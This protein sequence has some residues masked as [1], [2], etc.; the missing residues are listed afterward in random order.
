MELDNGGNI[1]FDFSISK[2]DTW[3]CRIKS[4]EKIEFVKFFKVQ[5][6]S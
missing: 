4:L 5:A 6:L 3:Y 2:N 1:R